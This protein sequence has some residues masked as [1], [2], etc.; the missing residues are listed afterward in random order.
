PENEVGSAVETDVIKPSWGGSTAHP[1]GPPQTP[2]VA[3]RRK[4]ALR[5]QSCQGTTIG[6]SQY[7]VFLRTPPAKVKKRPRSHRRP[8][9]WP[10]PRVRPRRRDAIRA[11]QRALP[12]FPARSGRWQPSP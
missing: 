5:N 3:T 12:D 10:D 8:P 2:A 6:A 11:R 7:L 4:H 9:D 1:P